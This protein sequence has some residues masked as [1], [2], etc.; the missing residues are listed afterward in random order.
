MCQPVLVLPHSTQL[1]WQADTFRSD[2]TQP[3]K[4][5]RFFLLYEKVGF[6]HK[7]RSISPRTP[8]CF[9]MTVSSVG[10]C[11]YETVSQ[12]VPHWRSCV[13]KTSIVCVSWSRSWWEWAMRKR[14]QKKDWKERGKNFRNFFCSWGPNTRRWWR[15]NRVSFWML[16]NRLPTMSY[17]YHIDIM[18][19]DYDI[20]NEMSTWQILTVQGLFL[21]LYLTRGMIKY[22]MPWC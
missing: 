11:M 21:W 15:K 19:F 3:K 7:T 9:N 20:D 13:Q 18:I 22:D 2:F 10:S 16:L 5:S 1:H 8:S 14:R 6:K 17:Q 4:H 12:D